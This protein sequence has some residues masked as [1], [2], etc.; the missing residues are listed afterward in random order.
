MFRH[1]S[2]VKTDLHLAVEMRGE[3]PVS[4]REFR[5]LRIVPMTVERRSD[6]NEYLMY[7]GHHSRSVHITYRH[8]I[9]RM[10]IL[11]TPLKI[12]A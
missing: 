3:Y 11:F 7:V 12:L 8:I 5:M 2:F 4:V 6:T 9:S 1:T 10:V